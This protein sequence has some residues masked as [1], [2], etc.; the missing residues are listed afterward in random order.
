MTTVPNGPESPQAE[1]AFLQAAD[2]DGD[3]QDWYIEQCANE[4]GVDPREAVR[5][6]RAA[7]KRRAR[8]QGPTVAV[9]E[10]GG[11]APSSS[12]V[13]PAQPPTSSGLAPP[14]GF[15]G[16]LAQ[17]I[18]GAAPRPVPE[19]AIVGALGLLAGICGREWNIPQ[20]GLNIYMVLV[21]RSAIGKEA[22]HSGIAHLV[23]AANKKYNRA[24]EFV[25]YEDFASGPA[26]VKHLINFP[27]SVNVAGELGHKFRQMAED[28]DNA[29][30][31]L[32]KQLTNLYSKSGQ[33]NIAGGIAYSNQE[34]NVMSMEGVAFSLI[35]E[36]T[37][38]PFFES[39][40]R[41]MMEDGFMSRFNVIE[42]TGDRPAKNLFPTQVPSG[43][44]VDH[45]VGLMSHAHLL[46]DRKQFQPV[47]FAPTAKA[48]LDA[49]ETE[50]DA[51]II[52]APDDE[53]RR[54]MWN[55]AHLKALRMSA[56]LA[57]GDH[58]LFPTV[59]DGH[60]DWAISL[61]RHDIAVFSKRIENGD[62]GEGS[63]DGRE[64]RLVQLCREYLMMREGDVPPSARKWDSI[65]QRGLV[66]HSYL[67]QKTQRLAAFEKYP[68]GHKTALDLAIRTAIDN[69]RMSVLGPAIL[70]ELGL[71]TKGKIYAVL[72]ADLT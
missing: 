55:R 51:A 53:G 24:R 48:M 23:A 26:L 3:E 72:D 29:M 28:K 21:A 57:V 56:L 34:N 7:Q 47:S 63:D 69:G 1:T 5:E 67:S 60:A 13:A 38:G 36:T 2:F 16:A 27:C 19:V 15:S 22:M 33:N 70:N 50:C 64:R 32:R 9:G 68:R 46:R 62:V 52:R 61:V 12:A 66:P 39:I 25:I 40:T 42:Y 49:F 59:S 65:R 37:P 41:G 11:D 43:A 54:Q 31:S 44:V 18:Y 4:I 14:P 10:Q 6:V 71:T 20:S 45:L 17:F 35:G 58:P 30:R 8:L